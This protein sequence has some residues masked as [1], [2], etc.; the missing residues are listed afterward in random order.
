MGT[1][2]GNEMLGLPLSLFPMVYWYTQ[3][4]DSSPFDYGQGAEWQTKKE[5]KLYTNAH[6]ALGCGEGEQ[7]GSAAGRLRG[8]TLQPTVDFTMVCR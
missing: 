2:T 8:R 1:G 4:A 6:S 3:T 5:T 7:G